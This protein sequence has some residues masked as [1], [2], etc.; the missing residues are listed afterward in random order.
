MRART[1]AVRAQGTAGGLRPPRWCTHGWSCRPRAARS[2][3]RRPR[4]WCAGS[5]KRPSTGT[6]RPRGRGGRPRPRRQ[7]RG[8]RW[9]MRKLK[10]RCDQERRTYLGEEH[11]EFWARR[12]AERRG[13]GQRQTAGWVYVS[14]SR[15]DWTEGVSA[16]QEPQHKRAS[17]EEDDLVFSAED[18]L[19]NLGQFVSC[20]ATSTTGSWVSA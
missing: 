7:G 19:D 17:S 16:V 14:S 13:E 11:G 18:P 4:Q 5:S 6:R 1:R 12:A 15:L 10:S 20:A 8:Q 2:P 9:P 3:W